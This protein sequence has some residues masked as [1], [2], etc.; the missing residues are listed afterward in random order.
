MKKFFA[1]TQQAALGAIVTVLFCGSVFA[2]KPAWAGHDGN[3]KPPESAAPSG[4]VADLRVGAY[5]ANTQR[6]T[7]QNYYSTRYSGKR[8]PPGL[9]KK[10]NGCQPPGQVKPWTTGQPLPGAVVVYPLPAAVINQLGTAPQGYRYVR[11]ANDLLLI[12]IGTGMV[13]DAIEDLMKL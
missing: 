5:F 8:C 7:V 2:G 1:P 11:V 3:D 6:H 9:A 13:I 4:P 10:H 12:A